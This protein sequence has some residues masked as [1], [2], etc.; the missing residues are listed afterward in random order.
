VPVRP[1]LRP[2][3]RNYGLSGL[4]QHPY[5]IEAAFRSGSLPPGRGSGWGWGEDRRG[6]A[7]AQTPRRG[8]LPPGRE[9]V[10][11]GGRLGGGRL[12]V[13]TTSPAV[14]TTLPGGVRRHGGE[15]RHPT[16]EY[17]HPG[18]QSS[19]LYPR[20]LPS[21]VAV[22]AA[23]LASTTTQGGGRRHTAREH[24]HPRWR[25]S[26][27]CPWTLPTWV[28]ALATSAVGTAGMGGGR[29]LEMPGGCSRTG[30]I[31]RFDAQRVAPLLASPL[32]QP[33][34]AQGGGTRGERLPRIRRIVASGLKGRSSLAKGEALVVLALNLPSS[35]PHRSAP[36]S[37]PVTT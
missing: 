3:L 28:A 30:E 5:E 20:T 31:G 36:L 8:S 21:R 11:A 9:V 27:P 26:P 25:S 14:A 24:R 19:P 15:D 1:G 17:R 16:R 10:G 18:W 6:V 13:R 23:L 2:S 7:S 33:P 37:H 12:A 29:R 35:S 22:V 32:T 34:P 4:K